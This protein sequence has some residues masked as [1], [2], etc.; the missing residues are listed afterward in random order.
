MA[1]NDNDD[2]IADYLHLVS[3]CHHPTCFYSE[4]IC[5]GLV[6]T[7]WEM[8]TNRPWVA[9]CVSMA[10]SFIHS[11]P[12]VTPSLLPATRMKGEFGG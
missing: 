6:A 9:K 5:M 1:A 7:T 2:S 3:F 10:T 11:S 4:A 8:R 12:R